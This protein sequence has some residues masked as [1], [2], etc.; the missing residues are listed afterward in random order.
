MVL[1]ASDVTSYMKT[2]QALRDSHE[3][4]TRLE[5][6]ESAAQEASALKTSFLQ[7]FSH[8]I[9]TPI[10]AVLGIC[11]LLRDDD[12]LA[13]GHLSLVNKALRSL[14]ILL[15]LVGMVLVSVAGEARRSTM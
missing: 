11:E 1:I 7:S 4:Q 3:E 13:P 9:R 8:E 6:S 12:T 10:T 15:E 5:L 2:K 14:E